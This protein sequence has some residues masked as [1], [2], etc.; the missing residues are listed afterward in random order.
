M[1]FKQKFIVVALLSVV[2]VFGGGYLYVKLLTSQNEIILL[3][4]QEQGVKITPY[5][6]V[7][8]KYET[9][10]LRGIAKNNP[11]QGEFRLYSEDVEEVD[12]YAGGIGREDIP[13]TTSTGRT[14]QLPNYV[15]SLKGNPSV[16]QTGGGSSQMMISG[17]VSSSNGLSTYSGINSNGAIVRP[18][19]PATFA[20]NFGGGTNNTGGTVL[21]D[22]GVED[23]LEPVVPVGNGLWI[24]LLLASFYYFVRKR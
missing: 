14:V 22:P 5:V 11:R 24:M 18:N 12:Y 4:K 7:S 9:T 3:S 6:I 19:N 13:L 17:A 20:P 2:V 10:P 16:S 23:D 1:N 21:S 8:Q 15:Q